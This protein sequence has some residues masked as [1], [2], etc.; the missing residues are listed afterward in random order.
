MTVAQNIPD[1]S[2]RQIEGNI[3]MIEHHEAR[4]KMAKYHTGYK[5]DIIDNRQAK[6]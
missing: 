3:S 6:P 5:N 2:E 4:H 1:V